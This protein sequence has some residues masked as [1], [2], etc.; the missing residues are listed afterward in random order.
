MFLMFIGLTLVESAQT[1]LKSRNFVVTKNILII[2]ISCVIFFVIG[3]AFAFGGTSAG[4]V[5]AQSNY[6]GVY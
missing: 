4:V 2:T 1:R 6:V 5:G 3:Y